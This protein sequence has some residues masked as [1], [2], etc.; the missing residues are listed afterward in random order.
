M[1][2]WVL[3]ALLGTGG[4]SAFA[5]EKPT[6]SPGAKIA[7][8]TLKDI[9]RRPRAL[10]DYKEKK[11]VVI[12]FLDTECPLANLYVPTLIDLH[13]RYAEKGVQFLGI[14]SSRQ[15]P[16]VVVSAHAQER[17][18]PFPVLKDFEHK[19]AAALGAKRT[20]EVFVLDEQR[21][22]RYRGRID[23]QYTL[24]ARRDKPTQ[25]ELVDAI[26]ALL[27]GRPVPVPETEAVGCLLERAEKLPPAAELT[28]TRHIAPLLQRHCQEC[29]RPGEIGPFS[30]LS[31]DDIKN[32]TRRIREAVI[33]E[34]MP[35]W[36]ADPR[37]G[38]FRNDRRLPP[39]DRALLLAWIDS[40]AAQGDD[41]DLPPPR[42]FVEGW[43]IGTPDQ[44]FTMPQE[45]RVPASG[46][47][48]YQRFTVD[49]GFREDV[50]IEAAECRP[51]N[52]A[53][54][55][56]IL[57]YILAPGQL[58]PYAPDGT[59]SMLAGWAPGDMPTLYTPGW[60][61]R[62]PA[63]S[64]LQFE[65]HYTPNGTPQT[66]RS[67]LGV[68]FAKN[69]PQ[70]EVEVNIL[71]NMRLRVPP[72]QARVKGEMVYTFR[73]DALVLSFMPHMHVRGI[74]A[75]Y[76]ATYPDGRTETL[77]SVP[78]YDFNWQ[79]VYRFQEPLRMPKGTKLT[80]IG[81]WDNSP[82]NPRNPDPTQEVF[83]GLQTWDEM[84][85]GWMELVWLNKKK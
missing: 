36:H 45:F 78:D 52:R 76:I 35:P 28:F 70:H 6:P 38:R 19:V 23:D 43:K 10:S 15:D 32:R 8:F 66:D 83:W 48:D 34:R 24:G 14:N 53:V 68:K 47:L 31:Y 65:V 64:R 7:N 59:A 46:V 13:Q 37:H 16:F 57:V 2:A 41:K 61:K 27:A 42:K 79:S 63:G 17:N 75:Q 55:H 51:G 33:E 67:S 22:L 81:Y 58:S 40:G 82:D 3:V 60:A 9:H 71:A 56:H 12:A 25:T 44:V 74:S 69:K 20:P 11:L 4:L 39:E 50:W 26:E 1:R 54:V 21:T 84:Q 85:N 77:L 73:D 18:I 72:R 30:L 62:I 49:P 5:S 29:H 80:W